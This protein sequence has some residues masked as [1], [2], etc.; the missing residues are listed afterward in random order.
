[1]RKTT[2]KSLWQPLQVSTFRNLLAANFLSDVGAFMQS[3]GAAWLM[4]SFGAG[5]MYVALT[6]TASSLAFFIL[7]L[8][9]GSIGDIVD[10][11]KLI[12]FTEAWMIGV[13]VVLTTVTVFGVMS[14]WLLLILTFAISA[15]DAIEAPSWRA[16]LPELV[17]KDELTA[18]S[19]LGGIEFNLARAVGP[20]L[21]G[22]VIA[23]AGVASAFGL[24]AISFI[25]VLLVVV[26]WKRAKQPRTMPVETMGG[27]TVAA[28][29]YVRYSP[30]IR[31]LTFR[32]GIV[33]F[34]ASAILALLPTIAHRA[35]GSPLSY[36]FLLGCF[37]AGAIA[38]A[39]VLERVRKKWSTEVVASAAV[40]LLGATISGTAVLHAETAI[41]GLMLIAGSAWIVFIALLSALVQNLAPDWV[42]A[43]VLAVYLLVFQ[44]GMAAGTALW[45]VIGERWS[46]EIALV[47][48]GVSTIATAALGLVWKL[49]NAPADLSPWIHWPMPA[50]EQEDRPDLKRG[51]V[52]IVVE[53]L[54]DR[55]QAAEFVNAMYE[56][57]RVRRRDGAYEWGI[58]HD[59]ESPERYVETFLVNSWA[60]HLRQHA[61]LTQADR[62]LEKRIHGFARHPPKVQHLIYARVA[63]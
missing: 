50:I 14:P 45:G 18:A 55:H 43:R 19:A 51:P 9:A 26:R 17:N 38:G 13:G 46:I 23:V 41:G 24:N 8:P 16:V 11:R 22:A 53:Y 7:A 42:R 35:S 37:G 20:A 62:H 63:E 31:R 1:M 36:G 52:L 10:R 44:G 15:G 30:A 49:P 56:Y 4:L 21:A 57:E 33:M 29:R 34:F 48:A 59:T 40:I 28:L 39:L 60:E 6:Q 47:L 3:V 2:S 25:G 54:V 58:F 5:P 61:R 12:I 27:A 32:A